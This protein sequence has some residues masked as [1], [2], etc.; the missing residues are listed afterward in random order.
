MQGRCA[1]SVRLNPMHEKLPGSGNTHRARSGSLSR[2]HDS[3]LCPP[4]KHTAR[5]RSVSARVRVALGVRLQ[6]DATME[7]GLQKQRS[8][9]SSEAGAPPAERGAVLHRTVDKQPGSS[10]E[11]EAPPAQRPHTFARS[12]G[13][14]GS[15]AGNN[16]FEAGGCR[17]GSATVQSAENLPPKQLN[18]PDA[19]R[20]P[21]SDCTPNR[22]GER[23]GDGKKSFHESQKPLAHRKGGEA[24]RSSNRSSETGAT[25]PRTA[26]PPRTHTGRSWGHAAHQAGTQAKTAEAR[27]TMPEWVL[28]PA[29]E[30]ELAAE[31]PA[32]RAARAG[33]FVAAGAPRMGQ[34]HHRHPCP[35]PP[36][37]TPRHAIA[38][39]Q[40]TQSLKEKK[41]L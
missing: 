40:N 20:G 16:S 34:P 3:T 36:P 38:Q 7:T 24:Q 41:G 14:D 1:C 9:N 39:C 31:P 26:P 18:G 30:P 5:Y 22:P 23:G 32:P 28:A 33:Q 2:A 27:S 15:S 35:Q 13:G 29:L 12:E 11:P 6:S 4:A 25:Y 37:Q 19:R 10:G 8:R 21:P 17:R